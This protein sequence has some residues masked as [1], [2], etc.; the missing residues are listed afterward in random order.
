[1]THAFT[2]FYHEH[3]LQFLLNGLY[4]NAHHLNTR[5]KVMICALGIPSVTRRTCVLSVIPVFTIITITQGIRSG[6]CGLRFWQFEGKLRLAQGF[7][8]PWHSQRTIELL[9]ALR[10]IWFRSW[11]MERGLKR[12]MC[13]RFKSWIFCQIKAWQMRRC[14]RLQ[15]KS[16]RFIKYRIWLAFLHTS[17]IDR[18]TADVR[19][20]NADQRR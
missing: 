8:S 17:W 4:L 12:K 18:S 6:G 1:M 20:I 19:Q 10:I 16:A 5:F 9:S 11:A 14:R 15:R 3:H 13:D 2:T 7:R